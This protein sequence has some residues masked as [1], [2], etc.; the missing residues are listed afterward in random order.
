MGTPES[1]N[2]TVLTVLGQKYAF[3]TASLML[4]LASFISLLGLEKALL[5]V[6][7]GYLALR[8]EPGP[9][10]TQRRDWA[11]VGLGL[12]LTALVGLPLLLLLFRDRLAVLLDALQKLP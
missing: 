2:P 4:G 8:R 9:A 7:F 10:L 12:G 11:R 6:I 3:A 5:A 1:A